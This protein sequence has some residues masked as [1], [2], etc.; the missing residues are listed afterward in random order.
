MVEDPWLCA[1][2][3]VPSAFEPLGEGVPSFLGRSEWGAVP[4]DGH[5]GEEHMTGG[6]VPTQT[7]TM[8]QHKIPSVNL[9]L[10]I[11]HL[12]AQDLKHWY[13]GF[14]CECLAGL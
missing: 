14:S 3:G 2:E 12:R 11:H 4:A 10:A 7:R 1:V 6:Q 5:L 13:R 9:L 8:T